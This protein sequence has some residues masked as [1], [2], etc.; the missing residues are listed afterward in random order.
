MVFQGISAI[1]RSFYVMRIALF[2]GT[3]NPIHYGHLRIAEEVIEDGSVDKVVFVPAYVPPHKPQAHLVD[4]ADRL[5]MIG[6]AI[7][8]N[9]RFALSDIEIM[10][11]EVSYTIDTLRQIKEKA[12]DGFREYGE[13][14]L[15]LL[16]GSDAFNDINTWCEY[17]EIFRLASI[18]VVTRPGFAVKKPG[19]VLP[20]ELARK[21]WYDSATQSYQNSY[22]NS[23]VYLETTLIG[24]SSSD[25]RERIRGGSSVR[26]MMPPDVIEYIKS[27][28]LY[29]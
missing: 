24:I 26:Y 25:I 7:K 19:E 20:V 11:G 5:A 6:L 22:G 17:E 28:D 21:F 9:E 27:K 29:R 1:S 18:I 10:R 15:S 23:L 3:F 8:G 2:G 4:A 14:T 16:V 13:I 12:P